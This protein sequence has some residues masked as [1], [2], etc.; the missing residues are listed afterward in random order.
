[1]HAE[2][3]RIVAMGLERPPIYNITSEMWAEVPDIY[4]PYAV[5][6]IRETFRTRTEESN[7]LAEEIADLEALTPNVPPEDMREHQQD[8]DANRYEKDHIKEQ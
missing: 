3:G 1:M 5:R 8:I 4:L 2:N 6:A 7:K